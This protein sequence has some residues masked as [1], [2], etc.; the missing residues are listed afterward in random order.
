[1]TAY[2]SQSWTVDAPPTGVAVDRG[3][4][5]AAFAGGDGAVRIVP[6]PPED[7]DLNALPLADGAVLALV[8][9]GQ[10]GAF[11]A[12][13]DDG[14]VYGVDVCGQRRRLLQLPRAW[15]DQLA[16]HACG[17]RAVA[18]GR[19]VR[20]LTACNEPAGALKE[21]TSTVAGMAFDR[22]G[23]QLAVSHYDGVSIWDLPGQRRTKTLDYHGSHL[24]LAWQPN[25]RFVVTATQEKML[26]AWD[27]RTGA[28]VSLGPC[29][30]IAKTLGWSADGAWLLASGNDTISA[31]P[32]ANGR[33]PLPAPKMLGR[34]SENLIGQVCPHPRL[35][36]TAVGYNDGGLELTA[37]SARSR[38]H[39]LIEPPAPPVVAV[40]WSPD[41][42]YLVGGDQDGRLFA[43]R[44]DG[45]WLA[46]LIRET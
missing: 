32:F 28:D 23:T 39:E 11:L 34:F 21:H 6:L 17:L 19:D 46:R 5:F 22:A 14:A 16:T 1:M 8:P 15:P 10:N 45:A 4:T 31:W 26:H 25:G 36:V 7:T 43:Y 35:A 29:F 30:N 42:S 37:I 44:F 24:G 13:A 20:L 33:L 9:D 3:G 40:A 12:G 18:D 41:G 38:R 27:L 2:E